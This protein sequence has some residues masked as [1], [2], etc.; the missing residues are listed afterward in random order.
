M[1]KKIFL[2]YVVIWA[3]LGIFFY[4]L[5][6]NAKS[7]V[8]RKKINILGTV[9]ICILMIIFVALQESNR[10]KLPMILALIIC[11]PIAIFMT[12]KYTFY[13]GSCGK[14]FSVLVNLKYC[15]KCGK[16]LNQKV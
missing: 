9:S 3:T 14:R 1:E 8:E 13:C 10:G 4:F 11:M 15:P 7:I 2:F 5:D 6:K 12:N 16:S